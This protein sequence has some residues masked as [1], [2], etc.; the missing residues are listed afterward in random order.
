[1]STE[2]V[3]CD[4]QLDQLFIEFLLFLLLLDQLENIFI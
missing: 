4:I 1:M 2:E 3:K